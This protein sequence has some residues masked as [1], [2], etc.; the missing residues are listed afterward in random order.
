MIPWHPQY[1]GCWGLPYPIWITLR[2]PC[3]VARRAHRRHV[4]L[5]LYPDP[6]L[7]WRLRASEAKNLWSCWWATGRIL[8]STTAAKA[9]NSWLKPMD[10]TMCFRVSKQLQF[11]MQLFFWRLATE[12]RILPFRFASNASANAAV[13]SGCWPFCRGNISEYSRAS[14][15]SNS[16]WPKRVYQGVDG[17]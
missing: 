17:I 9:A 11:E 3:W 12:R 5:Q 8:K 10:I 13:F 7:C 14:V 4:L 15:T 16:M 6:H 2:L 1:Y